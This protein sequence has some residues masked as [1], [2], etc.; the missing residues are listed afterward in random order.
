M[1]ISRD[2]DNIRILSN[3]DHHRGLETALSMNLAKILKCVK[4]YEILE[5]ALSSDGIK[6]VIVSLD[7]NGE[8][9]AHLGR[10]K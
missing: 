7:Q 3:V 1:A 10:G 8:I 2:S 6:E 9:Q 4:F 5:I